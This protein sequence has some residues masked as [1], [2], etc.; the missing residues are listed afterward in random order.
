MMKMQGTSTFCIPRRSI[1]C[2][3]NVFIGQPA[4]VGAHGIVR[5]EHPIERCKINKNESLPMN[6][7]LLMKHGKTH[8]K[9][10]L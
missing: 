8:S 7:Q 6:A 9:K 2:V 10:L 3:S 1:W 4:I 5:P